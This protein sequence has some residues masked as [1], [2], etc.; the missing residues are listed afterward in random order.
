MVARRRAKLL[1]KAS[2]G[3][4]AERGPS[5]PVEKESQLIV[6]TG[7]AGF[8][9][10]NLVKLLNERGRGDILVVDD[11]RDGRKFVNLA[12]CEILDLIDKDRFLD[13]LATFD[14]PEVIFH[15]GACSDTMEWDGR[16]MLDTNYHYSKRLLAYCGEHGIPMIYASSAAVSTGRNDQ[17]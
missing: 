9:G 16:Y 6:V 17:P 15:L 8:I 3:Q 10:S 1:V 13:E 5:A 12:D 14:P 2:Q 7:G 11:M 4:V